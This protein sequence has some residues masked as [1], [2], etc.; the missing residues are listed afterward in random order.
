MATTTTSQRAALVVGRAAHVPAPRSVEPAATCVARARRRASR[1]RRRSPR[2]ARRTA[3]PRPAGSGAAENA[4]CRHRRPRLTRSSKY[5]NK[6]ATTDRSP[7]PGHRRP[8]RRLP[9]LRHRPARARR[10]RDDRALG[11]GTRTLADRAHRA[12]TRRRRRGHRTRRHRPGPDR[13]GGR[14]GRRRASGAST[15]WCTPL[16][17]RPPTLPGLGMFVAPFEDVATAMHDLDVLAG[18]PGRAPFARCCRRARPSA[19]PR[20]IALDFDG[21]AGLPHVRLDG[22]DEGGP[23]V[24]R[25]L[26]RARGR[27]RPDPRQHARRRTDPH[28]GGQVDPRLLALRGHLGRARAARLGRARLL[29]RRRHRGRAALAAAARDD[30]ARSS[31][32]TAA[33]TRWAK[34]SWVANWVS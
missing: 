13:R 4:D 28:D 33:L 14:R 19:A 3:T 10:G 21:I 8:D 27:S 6:M 7:Y 17:T 34:C 5:A 26:P 24:A 11:R 18:R 29:G 31:T 16:A 12:Q 25:A 15:D 9:G 22:R 23:R 30:G 2:C 1:A 20:S 32:S